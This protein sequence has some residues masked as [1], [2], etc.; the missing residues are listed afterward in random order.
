MLAKLNSKL[1]FY[2]LADSDPELENEDQQKNIKFLITEIDQEKSSSESDDDED[3][4]R[5]EIGKRPPILYKND[6]YNEKDWD[7]DLA[8]IN[9]CLKIKKKHIFEKNLY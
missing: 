3:I 2:Y 5:S 7:T 1:L 4:M 9:F 8:G 6:I